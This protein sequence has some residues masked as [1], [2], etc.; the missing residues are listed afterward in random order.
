MA[1]NSV[2]WKKIPGGSIENELSKEQR[3]KNQLGG[4][5]KELNE[6]GEPR[7]YE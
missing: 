6:Y 7:Q 5:S 4:Y 1:V 3:G 2:L